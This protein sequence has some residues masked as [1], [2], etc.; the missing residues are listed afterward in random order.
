M[1]IKTKKEEFHEPVL[2]EEVLEY[3]SPKAQ[4]FIDATVGSGGHSLEIVKKGGQILGIDEDDSLLTLAE[5]RLSAICPKKDCYRLIQGNFRKIDEIAKKAGFDKVSGILFDLGVSNI[6]LTDAERGFSFEY[7]E[8]DLDMRLDPESEK[9]TASDLLNVLR[10]DQLRSLFEST[11]DPGAALWLTKRVVRERARAPIKK[12]GDFL[13]VCR[14]LRSKPGLKSATLPM[15]ALRIAVNSEL[16]NLKEALPK[17]L[18]LLKKSGRLLVIS[19]HSGED[20]IVKEFFKEKEKE[21]A[22]EIVIKDVV[23]PTEL[24]IEKNPR[25][26]SAKMRILQKI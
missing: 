10:A 14:Q 18:G 21:K 26:R 15:L 12:V 5:R 7:P 17:A 4:R 16:I 1:K 23:V 9:V 2:V 20:R 3:L 6:H 11:L 13:E 24:E 8:A 19:F 25:A 22:G